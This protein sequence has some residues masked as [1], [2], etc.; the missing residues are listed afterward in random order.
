VITALTD[1]K[2]AL[3]RAYDLKDSTGSQMASLH[4]LDTPPGGAGYSA[5]YMSMQSKVW[6]VRSA[7][8]SDLMMWTYANTLLP[9]AD[10]YGNLDSNRLTPYRYCKCLR[11]L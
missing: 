8:S 2:G 10:M 1:V 9:N 7:T 3:R 5:V 4:L 6:E 11:S